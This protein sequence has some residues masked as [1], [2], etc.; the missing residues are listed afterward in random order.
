MNSWKD[1][2][3]PHLIPVDDLL[4]VAFDHHDHEGAIS[5]LFGLVR[6]VS[7]FHRCALYLINE[8]EEFQLQQT[9]PPG[10]TGP[11]WIGDLVEDGIIDWLVQ[12]KKA[13]FIPDLAPHGMA[14][15]SRLLVPLVVR[16]RGF[17]FLALEGPHESGFLCPE[18][19]DQLVGWASLLGMKIE[20]QL[21]AE[22]ISQQR[23]RLDVLERISQ[24]LLLVTD[25]PR[26]LAFI[27]DYAIEVVP[28]EQAALVWV[29]ENGEPF[30]LTSGRKGFPKQR[31]EHLT[32]VE[33]WVIGKQS[34]LMVN[35]Y[36]RD[37]RFGRK[38][39][40]F[41][42]P[43]RQVLS[44]PIVPKQGSPGTLTLF[45]RFGSQEYTNRDFVFL[46]TLARHVAIAIEIADLYR[47]VREGYKETILALVNAIEAKDPYT[48]GH[49]ER[50]TR[51][52]LEMAD[53]L[54]VEQEE[55]EVL[56]Y[57]SLLHDVGK[58]GISGKILRKRGA[59]NDVEY[60]EIQKHPEIGERIV[61]DVRF[62]AR[63][64]P[65][66]RHH[67]ERYDG[68]GYPDRLEG[69]SIPLTTHILILAD[70]L[71]AMGSTRPYRSALPPETIRRELLKHAD[72]QFHPVVV[73]HALKLFF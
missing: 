7:D 22:K 4:G 72:R 56:E 41:A 62:L 13:R 64:R 34:P 14:G 10:R 63:A 24:R 27:L 69:P 66:I 19:L 38:G 46:S 47:N 45:N 9:D 51:Y 37:I 30:I 60:G 35:D 20:N 42:F 52:A 26:L 48:R 57:A 70:A 55:R 49:T 25:L 21:L 43:I 2:K 3:V 28:S 65:L 16:G 12:E 54:G 6:S 53:S 11:E 17:G 23:H 59:L 44:V 31:R 61:R 15:Q 58:I 50:V 68:S 71:D 5:Q 8:N 36:P 67:H 33:K 1:Q 29:K 73:E 32:P 18:E 40:D 39:E